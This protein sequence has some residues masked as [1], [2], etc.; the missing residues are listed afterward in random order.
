MW[1][2]LLPGGP[3]WCCQ[4]GASITP[5]NI[6]YPNRVRFDSSAKKGALSFM[7]SIP[8]KL[9]ETGR[10]DPLAAHYGKPLISG[11]STHARYLGRVVIELYESEGAT[12]E[13]GLAY[14]ID[15]ASDAGLDAATLA[16]RISEAFVTRVPKDADI[17]LLM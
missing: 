16:K 13:M 15:P 8:G 10:P 4:V 2:L 1:E 9:T 3:L 7:E 11:A 5:K 6:W 17:H 12:D 14:S